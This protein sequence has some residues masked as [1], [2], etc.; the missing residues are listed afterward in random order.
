M[1]KPL[2]QK[3]AKRRFRKRGFTLLSDYVD[4]RSRVRAACYCGN[5]NWYPFPANV[6]RGLTRS[7][8]CERVERIRRSSR[9]TTAQ[10][11]KR[12]VHAGLARIGPY[13]NGRTPIETKCYCGRIFAPRPD[14][15]GRTTFSCGCG[16]FRD[17]AGH[18]FGRV[19]AIRRVPNA[20][21]GGRW[22][23]QCDCG[24]FKEFPYAY[25]MRQSSDTTS[26][27]CTARLKH[28][29]S[30]Y[31]KGCGKISAT[32][33]TFVR[34]GA[35]VRNKPFEISLEQAWQLYES[36][37][38][39]C[40]L[41]GVPL[42]FGSHYMKEEITASLDEVDPSKGYV[43]G[44]LQWVH[45]TVNL[46]KWKH[47]QERFVE[48]CRLVTTPLCSLEPAQGCIVT[49]KGNRFSGHGNISAC[50]WQ[51]V[52][53]ESAASRRTNAKKRREIPLEITIE[54]AWQQFIRQRGRCMLTGLPLDWGRWRNYRG[55]ASLDR[56]DSRKGYEIGN[57]QWIHKHVN[58]MKWDLQE[59][60]FKEW[61]ALVAA[62]AE[63]QQLR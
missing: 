8:G 2:T 47:S 3:E 54:D 21:P 16:H 48:L 63:S 13:I 38:G 4:N 41:S 33:W 44:N 60:E 26:C 10:V 12:F 51:S 20:E 30:P 53:N 36:Q 18:R 23:C 17:I 29:A 1:G 32:F 46:M 5:D 55:S 59:E 61:C 24:A 52:V 15:V 49:V 25:L 40:L 56:I 43:A 19:I 50:F 42:C 27:G 11:D 22:L 34:K 7:C 58:V 39:R 57:I 62:H 6:F 35:E 14:S 45:K 31:W 37:D 9:L 28:S